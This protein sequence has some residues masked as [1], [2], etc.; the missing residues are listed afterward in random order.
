MLL[1]MVEEGWVSPWLGAVRVNTTHKGVIL[2]SQQ[3]HS[4]DLF[5]LTWLEETFVVV[6][7]ITKGCFEL[8]LTLN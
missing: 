3:P 2:E 4:N 5:I 6:Y 8:H 7:K 1:D